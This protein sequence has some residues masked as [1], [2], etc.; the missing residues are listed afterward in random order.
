MAAQCEDRIFIEGELLHLGGECVRVAPRSKFGEGNAVDL[1]KTALCLP[2][3][4]FMESA[5]VNPEIE[6]SE[7]WVAVRLFGSG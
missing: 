4:C 6:G 1:E 5:K 3:D 2:G 7:R